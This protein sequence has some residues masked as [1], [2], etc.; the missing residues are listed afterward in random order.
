MQ[1]THPDS[2]HPVDGLLQLAWKIMAGLAIVA[3]LVFL[4]TFAVESVLPQLPD[5][6]RAASAMRPSE[7]GFG[8]V[9]S[10]AGEPAPVEHFHAQFAL[11]PGTE[12]QPQPEAF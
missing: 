8:G 5:Q 4:G 2:A 1:L 11:R 3:G 9:A 12:T 10:R 6:A 7:I